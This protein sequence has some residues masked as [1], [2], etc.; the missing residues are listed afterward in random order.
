MGKLIDMVGQKCGR[1][2]VL[3]KSTK[4]RANKKAYW[5][6]ECECGNRGEY[7]GVDLRSGKTQSCG[8]LQ[9]ERTSQISKAKLQGRRFGRLVVIEECGRTASQ[10]VQW[11]CVCDCG[12]ETIVTSNSLLQGKTQSCGCY[13][14]EVVSQM[15]RKDITGQRFGKLVALE[16]TDQRTKWQKVVWA[17]QCDCGARVLIAIDSLTSGRT[18][19]CGCI[20]SFGEELIANLLS[21]HNL[22]FRKE[23]TFDNCI[24]YKGVK[25]RFDFWVDNHY[26]I[27][28]DG[29]QHFDC[30]EQGWDS[31]EH[32]LLTQS[33]DKIKNQYCLEYDI[34]L[35]RIPY[36][37]LPKLCLEDLLLE[38]SHFIIKKQED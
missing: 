37:H 21:F 5:I 29:E 38:T 8:C 6:C 19:S 10:N 9:K 36:T 17:C 33:Y 31:E 20:K 4:V 16:P 14:K 3:E 15:S 12:K 32:F 25:L 34:P 2:I 35:I 23:Q 30:T 27:E 22:S 28:F 11:K 18:K 1:L 13:N 24:G 7:C 26:L